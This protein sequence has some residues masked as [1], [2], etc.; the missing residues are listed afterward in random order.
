MPGR[1]VLATIRSGFTETPCDTLSRNLCDTLS[2]TA[3]RTQLAARYIFGYTAE[4]LKVTRDKSKN[5]CAPVA[6]RK[7][8]HKIW[9]A[10]SG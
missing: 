9:G 3:L 10:K 5:K 1:A 8:L 7:I 4:L 2:L 6:L